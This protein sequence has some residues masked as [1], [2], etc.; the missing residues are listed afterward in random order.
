M[1]KKV[2]SNVFNNDIELKLICKIHKYSRMFQLLNIRSSEFYKNLHRSMMLMMMLLNLIIT[3]LNFNIEFIQ[4]NPIHNTVALICNTIIIGMDFLL[5]FQIK[6]EYY[7]SKSIAFNNLA[8]D[9]EEDLL[10]DD[11]KNV[12]FNRLFKKFKDLIYT[13]N[14]KI[15]IYILKENEKEK[16]EYNAN[17][18]ESLKILNIIDLMNIT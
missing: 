6:T 4:N 1:E 5:A 16:I 9:I 18:L 10:I 13:E 14:D 8:N 3:I 11:I 7:K 2:K 12:E 15:P 17:E